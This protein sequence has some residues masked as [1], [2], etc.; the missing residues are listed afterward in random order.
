M[1][2]H[3]W[4]MLSIIENRIINNNYFSYLVAIRNKLI[5]EKF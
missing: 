2:C 1:L 5:Q 4:F 3:S